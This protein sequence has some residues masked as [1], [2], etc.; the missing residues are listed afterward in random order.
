MTFSEEAFS[1]AKENLKHYPVVGYLDNIEGFLRVLE[2][3]WPSFFLGARAVYKD[4]YRTDQTVQHRTMTRVEPS[5]KAKEIMKKRL[6]LDYR[7]YD[8]LKNNF[9]ELYSRL[10]SHG[11]GKTIDSFQ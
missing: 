11:E 3:L 5:Q 10:F 1:R 2:H 8:L 9:D 4:M 7:F 6:A